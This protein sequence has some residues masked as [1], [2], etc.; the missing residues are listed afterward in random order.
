MLIAFGFYYAQSNA[1][2][3]RQGLASKH[4]KADNT[5]KHGK[6]GITGI[7]HG[8]AGNTSKHGKAGNTGIQHR[9]AGNTGIQHGKAGN[10]SKHGKAGSTRKHGNQKAWRRVIPA[11][12]GR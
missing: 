4:R 8:K 11:S 9:K 3:I 6:A 5:S 7:Q 10:T 12:M 1:S 2:R